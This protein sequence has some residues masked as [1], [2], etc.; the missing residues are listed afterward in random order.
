MWHGELVDQARAV[1]AEMHALETEGP[2]AKFVQEIRKPEPGEHV[3]GLEGETVA[4]PRMRLRDHVG[5]R[6]RKGASRA[7]RHGEHDV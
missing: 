5:E 1:L 4:E 6:V 2:L 7:P 3:E